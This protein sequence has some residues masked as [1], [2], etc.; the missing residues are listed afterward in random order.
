RRIARSPTR[1]TTPWN[2]GA[3][4]AP[5]P[6]QRANR[7]AAGTAPR[8]A[9]SYAMRAAAIP[10]CANR[11]G[12]VTSSGKYSAGSKPFTSAATLH[13]NGA[14]SNRVIGAIPSTPSRRPCQNALTPMPIGVTAPRPVMTTRRPALDQRQHVRHR[15][16]PGQFLLGDLDLEPALDR[17]G[18]LDRVQRVQPQVLHEP[19]LGRDLL[20]R[21]PEPVR[22]D[23]AQA[24]GD[25]GGA[26]RRSPR[27]ST[28]I[29]LIPPKANE[30]EIAVRIGCRRAWFGT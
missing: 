1:S 21:D 24:G 11:T 26:H 4:L 30:L 16:Q 19:R 28:R 20:G 25:V 10:Y 12:G 9:S 29:A 3:P 14:G 5:L 7:R 15:L 27:P 23:L 2:S 18:E 8:P 6:K 17:D 22:H 13:G